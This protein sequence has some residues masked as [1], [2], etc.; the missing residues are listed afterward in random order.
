MCLFLCGNANTHFVPG[1]RLIESW[2]RGRHVRERVSGL[3][4][5]NSWSG[6]RFF[7]PRLRGGKGE[8]CRNLPGVMSTQSIP[9]VETKKEEEEKKEKTRQAAALNLKHR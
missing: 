8:L 9:V 3:S 1:Q 4:T 6:H 2:L 5:E 7:A